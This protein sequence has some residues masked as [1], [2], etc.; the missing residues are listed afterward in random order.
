LVE[1]DADT[2]VRAV[3]LYRQSPRPLELAV[4]CED[5]GSMLA[6]AGRLEEAVPLWDEAS[7]LYERLG[8]ER[9]IARVGAH[10]RKHGIKRGTRRRHARAT[11]G[12]EALTDTER[13]VIALVVQRLSNPEVAERLFISRHTVES[14]L[15]NIY[16]K[17]G[18]SSRLELAAVAVEH[19]ENEVG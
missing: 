19:A 4:A 6:S 5:A 18:L 7:E 10:L 1:Q 11:T 3:T 14:H 2:L 15:K 12:W 16:R 17:L 13:K 8:A 9:D